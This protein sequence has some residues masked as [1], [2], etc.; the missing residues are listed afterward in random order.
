MD[1]SPLLKLLSA[2]GYNNCFGCGANNPHGLKMKFYSDEQAVY[3]T[4]SIP[5]HLTSWNDMVHGGI[6]ATLLD[7]VMAWAAIYLQKSVVMTKSIQIDFIK[8]LAVAD[9]LK[10]TGQVLRQETKREVVIEGLIHNS[11]GNLCA[12]SEGTFSLFSTA[13]AKRLGLVTDEDIE[14]FFGPLLNG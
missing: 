7:E 5:Q 4:V 9:E 6:I 3:S 12:R 13:V 14:S 10:V 2:T 8:P 11:K 1:S